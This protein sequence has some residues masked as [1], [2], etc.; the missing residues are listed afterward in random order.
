MLQR[1]RQLGP[2]ATAVARAVAVLDGH[3]ELHHVAALARV[4]AVEPAVEA[5]VAAGFLGPGRPLAFAQTM[6]RACVLEEMTAAERGHLHARAAALLRDAGLRAEVLAPHLLVTEPAADA[7]VVRQLRAAA[8]HVLRRGAP[9]LARDYLRRALREPP[10]PGELAGVLSELGEAEW[11]CGDD[12]EAAA[13]HLAEAL[14]RTEDPA[15]RP[16]RAL[17]LH[18]AVFASGRLVEAYELLEREIETA[19]GGADPEDVWRMEAALASIGL[20]NPATVTRANA[21][22][23]RFETLDRQHAGRAAAG[24]QRRLLE[25]GGR[26]PRRRPWS[27]GGGRWRPPAPRPPTPRIRSRSTRRCGCSVTPTRTSSRC[28]C[29]TTRSP[30]PA[31]A[32]RCSG[33]RRRARCAR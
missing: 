11:C 22:L 1:L 9:D 15:L 5:L 8:A 19:S 26:A 27:T 20:L 6:V 32:G 21:R 23:A 4:P 31:L 13:E 18:Q 29:S 2:E 24:G 28:R 7:T 16:A 25:V 17:A 30:T 14:A 33:S 10:A 3:A 12:L